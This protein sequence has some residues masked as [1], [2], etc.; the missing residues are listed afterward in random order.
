MI[1]NILFDLGNVCVTFQPETYFYPKYQE[2][3]KE[4]CQKLFH[5]KHWSDYDQGLLQKE[6]LYQIY[7][8]DKYQKELYEIL[9]EWYLLLKVLPQT[10]ECM[11]QLKA[12]GYH[13][14]LLSNTS[15][16]GAM[17]CLSL[18][19][20][21]TLIDGTMFSYEVQIN[22]PDVGIYQAL[23]N[24]YHLQAKECIFIDDKKENIDTAMQLG[25][26][27][28]VCDDIEHTLKQLWKILEETQ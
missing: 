22:K 26:Q 2:I 19:S 21:F 10:M 3:T 12:K 1:H 4:L 6:D 13:L 20:A 11:Y 27:G 5:S 28:I 8:K 17:T 7:A 23:L 14:Y 16:E 15:K 9:D 24:K 25:M 18:D